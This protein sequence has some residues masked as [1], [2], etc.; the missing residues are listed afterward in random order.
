MRYGLIGEKLG[1]SFSKIIHEQ[2][3]D[4]TYDLIPVPREELDRFLKEKDFA[5]LNVTI[6]YKETVIPYLDE[7]DPSAKA[8]GAVNT[9]V[10]RSGRLCGYNTDFYGFRYLLE[11]NG[12]SVHGKKAL[13]LGNGGAAK[14]VVAVLRALGAKEIFIVYYKNAP[15]TISYEECYEKHSD[16]EILINATPV[17]MFPNTEE[18]PIDL[19]RFS[20]L[21]SVVDVIYNPLRTQLMLDAEGLGIKSIGGLEMLVAQAKYAVE[22][23]LDKQLPAGSIEKITS[24]LL[25]ERRNLV[26][27]GMSGAGKTT[28]GGLSAKRLGKIS[29]DTDEKIVEKIQIP[30]PAYFEA[31]GEAAFR[32]RETEILREYSTQNGLVISTGGGI[33]KNPENIR[34]LKKNGLI[35]WL[36]RPVALLDSGKGRPLAP[37]PEATARLYRERLPLYTAAA[38]TVVENDSTIETGLERLIQVWERQ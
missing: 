25:R 6:P 28:L 21:E 9:I 17:G 12:I 20:C 15:K 34:L 3:A 13:V 36:K 2:L 30:I 26:I 23:F 35:I 8:I 37:D 11:Y 29:V 19:R 16:A 1:H 4:Y 38:E 32:E 7:I 10:N 27:I 22:I 33:I 18:S 24:S 31:Y 5:A 14:A